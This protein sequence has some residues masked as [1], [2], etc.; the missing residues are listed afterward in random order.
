MRVYTSKAECSHTYV[1]GYVCVL[2]AAKTFEPMIIAPN[3]AWIMFSAEGEI[4]MGVAASPHHSGDNALS[5]DNGTL[6]YL[7][8]AFFPLPNLHNFV[9]SST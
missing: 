6:L 5:L 9:Y 2:R 1:C 8:F 7:L 4:R 3:L